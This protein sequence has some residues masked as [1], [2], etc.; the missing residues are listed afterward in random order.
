MDVFTWLTIAV[1]SA[2]YF[3]FL[4]ALKKV[5][6]KIIA[7]TWVPWR[8]IYLT[9]IWAINDDSTTRNESVQAAYGSVFYVVCFLIS[10]HY[11]FPFF[12]KENNGYCATSLA[13]LIST[14]VFGVAF[15]LT[16]FALST[17]DPNWALGYR[18]DWFD[19]ECIAFVFFS[20]SDAGTRVVGSKAHYVGIDCVLYVDSVCVFC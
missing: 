15:V 2:L 10:I 3:G 7:L 11:T 9:I 12:A 17:G 8:A 6:K 16:W 19:L 4:W 1:G 18:I 14:F 5:G 20:S 13:W